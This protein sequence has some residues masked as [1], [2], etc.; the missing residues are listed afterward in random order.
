MCKDCD[1]HNDTQD[2][3]TPN[4]RT[5]RTQKAT[6][7]SGI[8]GD[9]SHWEEN[10]VDYTADPLPH[11]KDNYSDLA[12]TARQEAGLTEEE[13]A[14]DLNISTTDVIAIE[15]GRAIQAGISGTTISHLETHLD[16][17]LRDK[18]DTPS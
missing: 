10:G 15:T 13:L 16:V 17:E 9:S 7:G 4:A 1:S 8:H 3:D 11:L 2:K 18:T 14:I 12:Q 6:T 5:E